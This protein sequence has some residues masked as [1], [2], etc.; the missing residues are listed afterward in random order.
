MS[1][2]P[3]SAEALPF[4]RSGEGA[5]HG[6]IGWRETIGSLDDI[7]RVE[8]LAYEDV[9]P[10][11]STFALL[12]RSARLYPDRPAITF[13]PTGSAEDAPEVLTFSALFERVTRAAMVFRDLGIGPQDAVGILAPTLP[14][15][16]V[17]LFAA[18]AAG[19]ACPINYMLAP[20]KIA[21]LLEHAGAKVLVVLGP[22]PDLPI[23][24]KV[25]DVRQ[26]TPTLS[27]VVT[28]GDTPMDGLPRLA[29]LIDAT[30]G[31]T[32]FDRAIG[33]DDIAAYYHT[34]GTT[35]S[36]KLVRHTHGNQVHASWFGGLFYGIGPDDTVVN[37]F[38]LFHVAGA[39]VLAG[40]AFAAGAN[41]LVPSKL[42]MRNKTFVAEF[43]RVCARH[44]VTLLSGGPTF[45]S[46]I[47]ERAGPDT[48]DAAAR[49]KA[50]VGGG[51]PM[52][53]E[54]ARAFETAF[55]IPLRS[56]YGMTEAAG[57][58]SIVP[59]LADRVP[60]ASGWRLPFGE[61][62][63]FGLDASG[64]IDLG[65]RL[66][67]G[68]TGAIAIRGPNLSPGYSDPALNPGTFEPDGWVVTGDLGHLAD[69][70][71]V[72]V[73]GRA[74]DVIIRGGHNI[75]PAG[76]EEALMQHPAVQLC[77]AVGQPDA[78]AGELPVAFVQAKPGGTA[79]AQE[80]LE[81]TAPFI[82]ERAAIPKRIHLVDALPLTTT[83]KI[84]KPELRSRAA[85]IVF[86]EQL[87]AVLA[88]ALLD[89]TCS[90]TSAG[91]TVRV[92]LAAGRDD[93]ATR[94]AVRDVMARYP[95]TTDIEVS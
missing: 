48:V 93:A 46:T 81:A 95:V 53:S 5:L 87:R 78:H 69:D 39:F 85:E 6:G 21:T 83:G 16:F 63:V 86:E 51:S 29:D 20:E 94:S 15:T 28:L 92:R 59:R 75:D 70:G 25:D 33:R 73:T 4:D 89:V 37:G 44:R 23:A 84:F 71:Q 50:L 35:G 30:P 22:D 60:G 49:I 61:I 42:G 54:L 47:L 26:R 32:G 41:T 3:A 8:G 58:I 11:R 17:A 62:A 13:L 14:D 10:V 80:I 65:R 12:E 40:S 45:V 2:Q 67:A 31:Q 36:P 7:R 68:E 77:A 52:P 43:W 24:E 90:E 1:S 74:K 18:E 79:S 82:Q 88:D 19:R 64:R 56:I 27:H 91:R 66:P 72:F 55:K 57:L 38:P 76:I 34:G 9:V